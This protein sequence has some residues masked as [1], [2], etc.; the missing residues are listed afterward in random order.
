LL[1]VSALFSPSVH[2]FLYFYGHASTLMS[3]FY[4][5]KL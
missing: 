5:A 1:H 3:T 2:S 4:N